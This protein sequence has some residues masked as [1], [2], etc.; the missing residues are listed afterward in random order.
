MA[1]RDERT[2]GGAERADRPT[3]WRLT[4]TCNC[5]R[6]CAQRCALIQHRPG[7]RPPQ[8]LGSPGICLGIL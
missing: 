5:A 4:A 1:D 6:D 8:D 7:P 2:C 3:D